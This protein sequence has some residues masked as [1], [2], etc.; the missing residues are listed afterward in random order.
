MIWSA[1]RYTALMRRVGLVFSLL[2]AVG[3]GSSSSETSAER[4]PRA[5]APVAPESEPEP[6]VV[7]PVAGLPVPELWRTRAPVVF[8]LAQ[9]EI[10]EVQESWSVGMLGDDALSALDVHTLPEDREA[11]FAAGRERLEGHDPRYA[12]AG[13]AMSAVV[14]E[15][16]VRLAIPGLFPGEL[17]VSASAPATV[18]EVPA[19]CP[20][21]APLATELASLEGWPEGIRR[22]SRIASTLSPPEASVTVATEADAASAWLEANGFAGDAGDDDDLGGRRFT[23]TSQPTLTARWNADPGELSV[24]ESHDEDVVDGEP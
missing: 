6:Q 20:R 22:C 17:H 14:G 21:L 19:Q 15:V 8:E 2:V 5:R 16:S 18:D 12:I 4:A 3:C 11:A 9:G 24:I 7:A 13:T 10:A 23:R 1:P